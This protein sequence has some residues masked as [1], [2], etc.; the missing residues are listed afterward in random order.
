MLFVHQIIQ[1]IWYLVNILGGSYDP[2]YPS[3]RYES[4]H[5]FCGGYHF[6]YC[7][8]Q[9]Q[10]TIIRFTCTNPGSSLAIY[11]GLLSSYMMR[12]R[13]EPTVN[14][15]CSRGIQANINHAVDDHM[16]ST[17][18]LSISPYESNFSL[19]MDIKLVTIKEVAGFD[20]TYEPLPLTIMSERH[21]GRSVHKRKTF[22]PE[23]GQVRTSIKYP[24]LLEMLNLD[25]EGDFS[26]R[27]LHQY[28]H[29]N[30]K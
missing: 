13:V 27:R 15:P 7:I 12:W 3:D 5:V 18:V 23:L 25:N 21:K 11:P 20:V 29:T 14:I 17:L 30:C 26:S 8:C 16:Y 19:V 9:W 28:G 24:Q 1:Y 6:I 22:D 2:R 4:C 10:V